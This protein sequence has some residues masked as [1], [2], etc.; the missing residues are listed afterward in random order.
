MATKR[1]GQRSVV[2]ALARRKPGVKG[3]PDRLLSPIFT[4][5]AAPASCWPRNCFL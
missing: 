2:G 3:R 5:S 1:T 4:G